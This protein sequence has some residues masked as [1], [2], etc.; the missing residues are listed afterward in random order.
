MADSDSALGLQITFAA[1]L[2][3]LGAANGSRTAITALGM[4]SQSDQK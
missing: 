1:A 4:F 2:T 3:A